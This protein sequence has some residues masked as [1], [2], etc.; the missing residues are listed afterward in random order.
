MGYMK[1]IC[2]GAAVV[3]SAFAGY[4]LY[5]KLVKLYQDE[6]VSSPS[7]TEEDANQVVSELSVERL[8]SLRLNLICYYFFIYDKNINEDSIWDTEISSNSVEEPRQGCSHKVNS[9][10]NAKTFSKSSPAA[11]KSSSKVK[12][13]YMGLRK[14]FLL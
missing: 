9:T 3:G 13:G 8:V 2:I 1:N 5:K 12:T 7:T 10:K 4:F 6:P 14:G 11:K